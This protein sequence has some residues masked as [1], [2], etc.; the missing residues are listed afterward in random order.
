MRRTRRRKTREG[1]G[2]IPISSFSDIAFLLII[3]F[4]LATTLVQVRGFQTEFPSGQKSEE[5]KEKTTTVTLHAGKLSLNDQ[6]VDVDGLKAGLLKLDLGA[7]SGD[8]KVVLFEAAGKAR[9][10]EYYQVMAAITSAGG[11][12]GIVRED[13]KAP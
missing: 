8:D 10:Q 4:I 12:V 6:P 5:K 3:F 1:A 13:A 9:Y 11:V 7:K 2:D